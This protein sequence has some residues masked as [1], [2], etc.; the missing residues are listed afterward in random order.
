MVGKIRFNAEIK[1]RLDKVKL[2]WQATK[3][4]LVR[5]S[6][7]KGNQSYMEKRWV[8]WDLS[9]RIKGSRV[10]GWI[11]IPRKADRLLISTGS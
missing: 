7:R 3:G 8:N 4:K 6:D 9:F 2:C 11:L 1:I 5:Y 10:L